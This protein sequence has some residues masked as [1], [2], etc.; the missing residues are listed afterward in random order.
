MNRKRRQLDLPRVQISKIEGGCNS[1]LAHDNISTPLSRECP[2]NYTR[3]LRQKNLAFCRNIFWWW[4]DSLFFSVI[5]RKDVFL[6]S[7]AVRCLAL[8]L[9]IVVDCVCRRRE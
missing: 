4:G 5:D 8:I 3:E 6:L 9:R 7:E 1:S 2:A